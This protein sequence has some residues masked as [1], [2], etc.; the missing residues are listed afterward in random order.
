MINS[1]A[2]AEIKN[3]MPVDAGLDIPTP[4]LAL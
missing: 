4:R 2:T 3:V 1:C